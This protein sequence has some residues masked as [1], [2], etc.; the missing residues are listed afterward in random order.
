MNYQFSFGDFLFSTQKDLIDVNYVHD[1]LSRESYWAKGIPLEIVQTSIANSTAIG[2]YYNS[3]QIGFAR[4]IH[5]GATFGYVA[6]VFIDER[7]RG[8]GLSKKLME[9]ILSFDEVKFFRRMVLVT[10][11]AHTLYQKYSFVPLKNPNN[12]MEKHQPDVYQRKI[13]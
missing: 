10:R 8:R 13:D 1:W 9:F 7:F 12:W 2:V 6:D 4:L 5:D 11:D 3:Q